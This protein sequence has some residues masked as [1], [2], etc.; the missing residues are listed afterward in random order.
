MHSLQIQDREAIQQWSHSEHGG[1]RGQLTEG[2][3]NDV[4][5]GS[6]P[7][8]TLSQHFSRLSQQIIKTM[9]LFQ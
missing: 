9:S 4:P 2:L 5:K 1:S 8:N 3:W 6:Q 7:L